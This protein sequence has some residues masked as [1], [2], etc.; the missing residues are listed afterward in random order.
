MILDP[1]PTTI[2]EIK[3]GSQPICPYLGDVDFELKAQLAE[4]FEYTRSVKAGEILLLRIM[5]YLPFSIEIAGNHTE[6]AGA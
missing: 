5:H 4:F 2:W 3:F 1:W 6:T